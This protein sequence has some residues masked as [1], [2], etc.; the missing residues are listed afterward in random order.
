MELVAY[1]SLVDVMTLVGHTLNE[2]QI[3]AVC[4]NALM[5]L[6]YLHQV[7]RNFCFNF[8]VS[9]SSQRCKS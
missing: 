9:K 6:N 3:S 4:K 5:G 1:G 7:R 2:A 8:P